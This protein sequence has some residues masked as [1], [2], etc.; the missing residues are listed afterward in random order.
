MN[1]CG[2]TNFKVPEKIARR[3]YFTHTGQC[4]WNS[5]LYGFKFQSKIFC[6][7]CVEVSSE[8]FYFTSQ[9]TEFFIDR[10]FV[11]LQAIKNLS[12]WVCGSWDNS[13]VTVS[14]HQNVKRSI[15]SCFPVNIFPFLT[16]QPLTL[17]QY[18]NNLV[19]CGLTVTFKMG[20]LLGIIYTFFEKENFLSCGYGLS[21]LRSSLEFCR[22]LYSNVFSPT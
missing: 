1:W 8:L 22:V 5:G 18:R 2:L 7:S 14:N 15:F 3:Q 11:S 12:L 20:N 4:S 21:Q 10:H 13:Q 6:F 9:E 19:G 17:E 16:S